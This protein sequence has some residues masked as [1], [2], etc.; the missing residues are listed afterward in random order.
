MLLD[1]GTHTLRDVARPERLSQ[2][3]VRACPRH[4][5]RFGPAGLLRAIFP[6]G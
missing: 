3:S 2:L 1:L 4:S 5:H 6:S